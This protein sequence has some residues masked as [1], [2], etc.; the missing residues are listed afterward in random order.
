MILIGDFVNCTQEDLI[1]GPQF[2]KRKKELNDLLQGQSEKKVKVV[3]D[4]IAE[5]FLKKNN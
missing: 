4:E 5:A 2:E 1:D 3:L